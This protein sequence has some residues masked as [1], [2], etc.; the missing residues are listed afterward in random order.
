[1]RRNR[2]GVG[3]PERLADVVQE[4]KDAGIDGLNVN[5]V[6][7]PESFEDFA[8]GLAPELRRR[9]LLKTENEP[10]TLRQKLFGTGDRLDERHPVS[11]L[12]IEVVRKVA[13]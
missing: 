2:Q 11:V 5:W 9:G 6:T 12:R 1:M 7:S 3:S 10:G 4:W 13:E 8:D